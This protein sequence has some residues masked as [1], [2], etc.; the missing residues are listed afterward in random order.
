MVATTKDALGDSGATS[1]FILVEA[2]GDP[3]NWDTCGGSAIAANNQHMPVM[4]AQEMR[5][6]ELP[7]Q[8]HKVLEGLNDTILSVPRLADQGMC[9]RF[10]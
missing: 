2:A 6:Q 7:P 5:W 3:R 4:G 10:L 8:T 9:T 1:N